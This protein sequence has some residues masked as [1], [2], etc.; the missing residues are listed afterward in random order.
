MNFRL[1]HWAYQN[2][3]GPSYL[4]SSL[5]FW[6]DD[7]HR[8]NHNNLSEDVSPSS[9]FHT[10]TNPK[11]IHFF[12]SI[13]LVWQKI[14]LITVTAEAP[15]DPWP[16][17]LGLNYRLRPVRCSTPLT[18]PWGCSVRGTSA[19]IWLERLV[20]HT[21]MNKNNRL[22]TADGFS[23]PAGICW[24]RCRSTP[25]SP[26]CLVSLLTSLGD[27]ESRHK[28]LNQIGHTGLPITVDNICGL[29]TKV[30]LLLCVWVVSHCSVL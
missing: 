21:C 9:W 29:T 28:A 26:R 6:A 14:L 11:Q 30:K 13:C 22:I 4:T 18:S 7:I 15:A 25:V 2:L 12:L 19:P 27:K 23:F 16:R 20:K 5:H 10:T 8:P 3:A 17:C 1:V 24:R